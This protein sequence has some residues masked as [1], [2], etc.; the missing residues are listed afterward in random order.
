MAD[1]VKRPPL[2]AVIA[3][4]QALVRTGFGMILTADGIEV[5]AEAAD[6]AEAVAAVRRTRPDV[7]LM[8]IRMPRMDGIEA[9]RRIL[10]GD[11]SEGTRVIILTTYDLDHYVYAAL[12]AG[13]S[14]F[15]LKDVTPEH[16]VGAV[17]LV[18]SGDALLAPAITRRLIERFAHREEDRSVT[19]H[20]DL[21]GLTPRELEVL[22]LL[23]T[24]LSNAELAD[25]LFLSPTTVKTHI[26]RILSK[27][28]LRDRVQAVVLAYETGLISPG[29]STGTG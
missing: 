25:R 4:D 3:D 7:V 2:R 29:G 5:T 9:T 18:Q 14:G 22:R 6:G 12:T 27:L 8:D 1:S 15:L 11:G 17:R 26:G 23:A 10:D 13:A 20:R 16:L 28:D 24:G 21:S 19:L